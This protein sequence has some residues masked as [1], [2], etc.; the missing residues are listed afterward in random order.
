MIIG[1]SGKIGYFS[2]RGKIAGQQL[3]SLLLKPIHQRC[4]QDSS[5]LVMDLW[6]YERG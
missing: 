4:H 1:L 6:R 5:C 3:G 2:W